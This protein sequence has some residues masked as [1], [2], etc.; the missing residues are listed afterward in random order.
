MRSWVRAFW[1]KEWYCPLGLCLCYQ[2]RVIQQSQMG[3]ALGWRKDPQSTPEEREPE[4]NL[5]TAPGWPD[6][7]LKLGW[8]DTGDGAA[9]QKVCSLWAGEVCIVHQRLVGDTTVKGHAA[10]SP[11]PVPR[12]TCE[13]NF[14]LETENFLLSRWHK[15]AYQ[16]SFQA[17]KESWWL[18]VR[19]FTTGKVSLSLSLFMPSCLSALSH[20]TQVCC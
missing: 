19:T 3:R 7:T 17:L 15:K 20:T 4:E 1:D 12:G 11:V 14:L 16:N 9:F 5:H 2:K 18:S 10:H 13:Q 8:W 6:N